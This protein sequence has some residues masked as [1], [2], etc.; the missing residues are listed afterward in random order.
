MSENMKVVAAAVFAVGFCAL[1]IYGFILLS[2]IGE[3]KALCLRYSDTMAAYEE[4]IE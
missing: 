2:E 3:K 4:C 1:W